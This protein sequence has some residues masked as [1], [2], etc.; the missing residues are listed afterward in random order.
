[1]HKVLNRILI[2]SANIANGGVTNFVSLDLD[3][4]TPGKILCARVQKFGYRGTPLVHLA[5]SGDI[6]CSEVEDAH[7]PADS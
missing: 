6:T 4:S 3:R 7:V 5:G 1:M 2:G